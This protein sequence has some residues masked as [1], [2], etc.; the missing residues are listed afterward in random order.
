MSIALLALLLGVCVHGQSV[1]V[2]YENEGTL[3]GLSTELLSYSGVID[4]RNNGCYDGVC[5][6]LENNG[7]A[8]RGEIWR[9]VDTTGYTD[10][11]IDV[12]IKTTNLNSGDSCVLMWMIPF[13]SSYINEEIYRYEHAGGKQLGWTTLTLN[14]ANIDN[15]NVDLDNVPGG[16]RYRLGQAGTTGDYCWFDSIKITGVPIGV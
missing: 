7:Q 9:E 16:F 5:L 14:N 10:V 2:L 3:G 6:R 12:V 4:Q 15:V 11:T 8:S 13:E 1:T